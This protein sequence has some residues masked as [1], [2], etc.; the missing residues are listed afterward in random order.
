MLDGV[1][2]GDAKGEEED[3]SDGEEGD[4]K[5][6]VAQRPAVVKRAEDEDELGDSI[7]DDACEGPEDVG[8]PEGNGVLVVEASKFLEGGDGYEELKAKDEKAGY[9]EKLGREIV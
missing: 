3:L 4:A 1:A 5:E 8:D 6:D 2:N 9:A 7:D